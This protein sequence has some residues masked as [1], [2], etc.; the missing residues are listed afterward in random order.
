[1]Q[2]SIHGLYPSNKELQII[3]IFSYTTRGIPGL[4][5][6][7]IGSKSRTIKEK[8][9]YLS[10]CLGLKIPPKRYV[11]TIDDNQLIKNEKNIDNLKWLELPLILSFWKLAG[12]IKIQNLNDCICA[13]QVGISAK[14]ITGILRK[15][16]MNNVDNYFKMR[17]KNYKLISVESHYDKYIIDLKSLLEE[18]YD[19]KYEETKLL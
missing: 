8:F 18:V 12:N 4:E 3:D 17:N 10:K 7:G 19:F 1:V 14:I 2:T 11:L 5:I 16:D 6:N 9:I 15:D 13:G